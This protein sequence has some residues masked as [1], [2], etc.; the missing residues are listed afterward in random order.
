MKK[1]IKV[2]RKIFL[3]H[4]SDLQDKS[5][6]FY[7]TIAAAKIR[8]LY[9]EELKENLGFNPKGVLSAYEIP[10]LAYPDSFRVR[11]FPPVVGP[12]GKKRKYLQ[13]IGSLPHLY[14]CPGFPSEA[15]QN[16]KIP[17]HIQ[18]GEKKGLS[19]SQQPGILA[20]L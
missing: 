13:P 8:S 2:R 17:I 12:D 18:E 9:P 11:V 4:L 5:G 10:N 20:V 1:R 16:V 14:V 15:Y 6:L 7:E 3:N 19:L